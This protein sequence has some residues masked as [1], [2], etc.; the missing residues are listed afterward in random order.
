MSNLSAFP[1]P[2]Q[3]I[4]A[5]ADF[6]KPG[7]PGMDLRDW[8]AGQALIGALSRWHTVDKDIAAARAYELADAMLKAREG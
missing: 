1:I 7:Q 8:F 6:F 2:H 3:D 4:D 5:N